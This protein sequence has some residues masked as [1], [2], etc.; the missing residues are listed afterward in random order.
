MKFLLITV[1]AALSMKI[2][3]Y[4]NLML[5]L[6]KFIPFNVSLWL[7]VAWLGVHRPGCPMLVKMK[8]EEGDG[9]LIRAYLS[10]LLPQ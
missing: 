8:V 5:F 10:S 6:L 4:I 3:N 2:K 1:F 9:W 7:L